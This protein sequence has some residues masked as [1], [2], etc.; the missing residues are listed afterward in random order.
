MAVDISKELV[1]LRNIPG[2]GQYLGR[3]LDGLMTSIASMGQNSSVDSNVTLPAPSPIQSL[4]VKASGGLVHAVIN[5]SAA[6]QKNVHYFLEYSTDAAFSQPWVKHLG[7]SRTM[8]PI[9]LPAQDDDGNPQNFHFRAY[10]QQPGGLPSTPVNF[11]PPGAPTPVSPGG[12][13]KLTLI[14]STGSGTAPPSGESAG[15]GF[16]KTLYRPTQG[17]KRHSTTP[18]L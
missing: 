4:T 6:L 1:F 9:T 8:E 14:P 2:F 7:P 5:D 10:K 13:Q 12:T 3:A 16:G 15:Q 17:P 18:T 11:G